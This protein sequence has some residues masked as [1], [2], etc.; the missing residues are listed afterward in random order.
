MTSKFVLKGFLIFLSM[1][2]KMFSV[3]FYRSGSTFKV[4]SSKFFLFLNIQYMK[5]NNG[6]HF[7]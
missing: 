1:F 4:Q 2:L 6:L 5:D 7:M 3:N